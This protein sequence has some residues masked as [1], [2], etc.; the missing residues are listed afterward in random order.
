M[1]LNEVV[2]L[3]ISRVRRNVWTEGSYLKLYLIGN[4]I[5]PWGQIYDRGTQSAIGAPTPQEILV[6]GDSCDDY[7]EYVG[8]LDQEDHVN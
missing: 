8:E 4:K 3:G 7:V 2:A 5:G 6:M 1:T